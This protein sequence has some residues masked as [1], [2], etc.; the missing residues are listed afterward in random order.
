MYKLE[1]NLDTPVHF[2]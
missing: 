2:S 1:Q